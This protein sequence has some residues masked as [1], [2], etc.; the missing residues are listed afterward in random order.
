VTFQNFKEYYLLGWNAVTFGESPTFQRNISPR[1]S[2]LK[3]K[4]RQE[5]GRSRQ[6]V[7]LRFPPTFAMVVE[8]KVIP[9]NR[10]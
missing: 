2:G 6:Q 9:V 5:T 1:C 4:A 8:G 3:S 10:P 7:G